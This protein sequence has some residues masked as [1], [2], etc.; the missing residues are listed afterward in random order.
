[1]KI[2][3]QIPDF[4]THLAC[5][6]LIRDPQDCVA[7]VELRDSQVLLKWDPASG[8]YGFCSAKRELGESHLEALIRSVQ[9]ERS[10][11]WKPD[12]V[13]HLAEFHLADPESGKPGSVKWT[14]Y[15]TDGFQS[16]SD[17]LRTDSQFEWV[18]WAQ[19]TQC[20]KTA[21]IFLDWLRLN[22]KV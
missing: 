1:M 2:K 3:K 12:S 19:K 22:G 7:W 16:S 11:D 6:Q 10:I 18:G 5:A 8:S 14:Y 21:Q 20:S 13:K 9:Q 17:G 15:A 4:L